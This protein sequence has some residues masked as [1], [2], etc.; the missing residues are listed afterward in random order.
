MLTEILHFDYWLLTQIN[1]VL[2]FAWGD[3]FF[4]WI[5]DLHKT[6]YFKLIVIPLVLALF[7]KKY[8]AQGLALFMILLLAVGFSDFVG[9]RVKHL[10]QRERPFENS[11]L[12]VIKRSDA[13]GYSF[14]SNHSSN[15]FTFASYSSTFLPQLRIP[16]FLIAGAVAYSRVYDGVHYPSD[17][18]AGSLLGL[19]WGLLFSKLGLKVLEYLKRIKKRN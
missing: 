11:E 3:I 9:G 8:R 5:T 13:G 7:L 10:P 18:L 4:P 17:V 12:Q 14:Y 19:L 1:S 2:S 6:P 16:L 15:M